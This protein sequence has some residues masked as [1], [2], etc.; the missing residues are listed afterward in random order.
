MQDDDNRDELLH[1]KSKTKDIGLLSFRLYNKKGHRFENLSKEDYETFINL[2]NNK[3][4]INQK[5]DKGNSVV[6]IDHMSYISK[7]EELLS[8]RSKFVKIQS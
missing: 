1:V 2:K 8:D 7:M 5:A 6:I 3:N 4:I